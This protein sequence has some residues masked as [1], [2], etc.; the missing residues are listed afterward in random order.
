MRV[1][2]ESVP[3]HEQNKIE[4]R[5]LSNYEKGDQ[6]VLH[7]E[8]TI[9]PEI[10]NKVVVNVASE[11]TEFK[12]SR[13]FANPINYV[14]K[15]AS[16]DD[17]VEIEDAGISLL[18]EMLFEED[19]QGKDLQLSKTVLVT[20]IGFRGVFAKDNEYRT[21]KSVVDVVQLDPCC[22]FVVR[23]ADMH[24][25]PVLACTY[26]VEDVNGI[27]IKHYTAYTSDSIY[28][29][30]DTT[31]GPVNKEPNPIGMI[32]II[33]YIYDYER[34]GCFERALSQCDALNEC[35]SS[36]LDGLDQS[37]QSFVWFNNVDIT[38]DEFKELKD[39]GGL[40]T[41]SR[42]G[43]NASVEFLKC[44]LN[45]TEVQTLADDYYGQILRTCNV[46][47]RGESS[48]STTGQS[49]MLSGGWQEAD[50]AANRLE[51][52]FR[53]SEIEFIKVLMHII[54][55]ER[56]EGLEDLEASDIDVKFTR[57]NVSN[58]LSKTQALL[59]MLNAGVYPLRALEKVG[60]FDDAQ[61]TW[62]DSKPYM[63]KWIPEVEPTIQ[64]GTNYNNNDPETVT[65]EQ[66][67]S[68][69]YI[70]GI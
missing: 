6:P 53:A 43:L 4:C 40:V 37:I 32:P 48:G 2:Q 45:Q 22:T 25:R 70:N 68:Q 44:D 38:S 41:A 57:N 7:R 12:L 10:N 15:S 66:N 46:P 58:L 19:K 62:N 39:M 34:M 65:E 55:L 18:N 24:H 51:M 36:R 30:D 63:K 50:E 35:A 14:Q 17:N 42:D 47:S 13:S 23:S 33:E 52:N 21:G 9:R 3:I 26:W 31:T 20:G 56:V 49:A 54:H 61:Q 27:Y 64:T 11:V 67:Q 8:K 60:L 59:N 16:E 28:T 29:F 69:S 5:Y 1:I